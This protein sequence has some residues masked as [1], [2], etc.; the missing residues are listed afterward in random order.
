[1]CVRVTLRGGSFMV[2]QIRHMVSAA[3][4]VAAGKLPLAFAEAALNPNARAVFALAPAQA[5]Y[6]LLFI[7]IIIIIIIII[8]S[9]AV[10]IIIIYSI[11]LQRLAGGSLNT[12]EHADNSPL[13]STNSNSRANVC[14][15][16]QS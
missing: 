1:M 5:C 10:I 4:A 15:S 2:H 13:G 6:Y 3:A 12:S 14:M 11:P 9:I 8:T 16:V 7:I